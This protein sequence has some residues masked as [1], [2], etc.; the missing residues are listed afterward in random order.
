MKLEGLPGGG[1]VSLPIMEK[2]FSEVCSSTS[3]GFNEHSLPNIRIHLHRCGCQLYSI[4]IR[5]FLHHLPD[6]TADVQSHIFSHQLDFTWCFHRSLKPNGI[7]T[8][9]TVFPINVVVPSVVF[10]SQ[11][12]L[13]VTPESGSQP[14]LPCS[15]Y[16]PLSHDYCF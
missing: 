9:P 4:I 16:A 6:N 1:H 7:K 15:T 3:F 11:E 10:L 8:E 12:T 5:S 14:Q 13:V 2:S